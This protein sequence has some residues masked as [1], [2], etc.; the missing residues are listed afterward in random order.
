PDGAHPIATAYAGHQFGVFVPVL[1]DGRAILLGELEDANG[2]LWELQLKGIGLTDFSR[3]GDGKAPLGAVVREYLLS[4]AMYHLGIPTTR[5]LGAVKTGEQI[6]RRGPTPAGVIAR[7]ASSH[8]RVGTFEYFAANGDSESLNALL[9]FSIR[10]HYPDLLGHECKAQAFLLAVVNR[11]AELVAKWMSV[12]FIHGVMNTDNMGISGET[13]DYGPCAF[14]DHYDPGTVFSS[15]DTVGR[16]AYGNQPLVAQWNLSRLAHC[17]LPLISTNSDEAFEL[18]KDSIGKFSSI[19]ER[20][21]Y[22][23]MCEKLGLVD[24]DDVRPLVRDFLAL[25]HKHEM[26]YTLSFRALSQSIQLKD[27]GLAFEKW[28]GDSSALEWS[29]A[30]HALVST[31]SEAKE[32]LESRNPLYIPRNHL[33]EQAIEDFVERNDA[34]TFHLL[35]EVW[36]EPFRDQG[37]D[38]VKVG[39][40]SVDP[41]YQTFCGT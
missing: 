32:L 20:A 29:T 21:W 33:V 6:Y 34:S 16:Y 8:V 15:I 27:S 3:R 35:R 24:H 5:S 7:I 38:E 17:L 22:E 41:H 14:M 31:R 23:I 13:L 39:P 26:D 28:V 37:H 12:G 36:K 30:W 1:G 40:Q 19:Y 9:E 2:K 11:Q 10:R 4:E 25:L 18:A